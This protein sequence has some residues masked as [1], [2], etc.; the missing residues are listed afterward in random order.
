MKWEDLKILLIRLNM[1]VTDLARELKCARPSIYLAFSKRNRPGVMKKIERFYERHT[2]HQLKYSSGQS[3]R[4]GFR[5]RISAPS[6][7]RHPVVPE[8]GADGGPAT[9]ARREVGD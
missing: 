2:R 6:E 8:L 5:Q 7:E 9:E 1:T 4:K 3:E